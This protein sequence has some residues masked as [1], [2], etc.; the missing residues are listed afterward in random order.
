MCLKVELELRSVADKLDL[1]TMAQ[2]IYTRSVWFLWGSAG[3]VNFVQITKGP[4]NV[5]VVYT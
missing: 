1:R 5:N 2:L 4:R 3:Q